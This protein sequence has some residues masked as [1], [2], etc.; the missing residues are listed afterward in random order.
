MHCI[1]SMLARITCPTLNLQA[2]FSG[3]GLGKMGE[4][5]DITVIG[6][7]NALEKTWGNGHEPGCC[8][9]LL[10]HAKRFQD[11]WWREEWK[12]RRRS[13]INQSSSSIRGTTWLPLSPELLSQPMYKITR[14]SQDAPLSGA[15]GEV[16][17][18]KKAT[19]APRDK[20]ENESAWL[21]SAFLLQSSTLSHSHNLS[22]PL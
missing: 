4:Q 18:R 13:S 22:H 9:T 19:G 20:T 15:E 3:L 10:C 16:P 12:R 14:D 6:E 8:Y 2:S 7:K 1:L 11:K 17:L 5:R 21:S